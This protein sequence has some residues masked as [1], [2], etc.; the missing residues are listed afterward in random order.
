M[1]KIFIS[2]RSLLKNKTTSIIAIF[3]FSVSL[4]IALNIIA[5]VIKE[6]NVDKSYSNLDRIYR[7]V[8][9]DRKMSLR[10]DFGDYLLNTHPEIENACRYSNFASNITYENHPFSGN[11]VVTDPSF[12][13]IFSIGFLAGDESSLT[14]PD[15]VV[16]TESFARK[17]FGNSDPLGKTVIA[18][19]TY[20]LVIKGIVKDLPGNS[21]IKGDYFTSSKRKIIYESRSD[22]TGNQEYYFRLFVLTT[23]NSNPE[24]LSKKINYDLTKIKYSDPGYKIEKINLIPFRH[25]YFITSLER[26]H[27]AHAN[28]KLIKLL[29]IVSAIII[30][31]AVFNYVNLTTA[32]HTY[33]YKE[34]AI[35]KSA[36]AGRY[37]I[38][39]Q[40]MSESVIL[41]FIS[42]LLALYLSTFLEPFIENFIGTSVELGMLFKPVALLLMV[43][44]ILLLA[45]VAG[46]YPALSIS[47]LKPSVILS[48]RDALKNSSLGLRAV[49]NILQN[50]VSV[51][52][53][54]ALII[55]TRQIN[56]VRNTNFGFDAERLLR[57]DI[58]WRLAD[59]ASRIRNRLME[60]SSVKDVCFTHGSPG[61]IYSQSS[62]EVNGYGG[63]M[64]ELSTDS[65]FFNVFGIPLVKGRQPLPSDFNKVCYINETAFK[66]TG[67]DSY[68]G[69]DYHGLEVIGVVKD[70]HFENL[71]NK[72]SPL[73]IRLTSE[74]GISHMNLRI[75][76][77]NLQ[78]TIG[79]LKKTWE[80]IFPGHEL[81]YQFYDDW[82][83]SMYKSEEKLSS[84]ISFFAVFAI[85]ISCLGIMGMAEFTLRKRIKEIGIRKVNGARISEIILL[86]TSDV[87][88]Y[89][90]YGFL[91]AIIPIWFIMNSWLRTFAYHT[92]ADWWIF[93][94]AGL[95]SMIVG[96]I[97]VS[98]QSYKAATRNPL[99]SLRYE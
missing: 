16:L 50:A 40:F 20:P 85:I 41:C 11:M 63:F 22:G 65:S 42:F 71:Y 32:S 57:V 45:F 26:S 98:W 86:L 95:L 92:M 93:V 46:F 7:V 29:I 25:S 62:W 70:F 8:S 2:I 76:N 12:F 55:L 67:W 6:Y 21:S 59:K 47:R 48:K 75:S 44:G 33:R 73:A 43:A 84:A 83:D 13:Q 61:S 89:S 18:E 38:F 23:E 10:E 19:Y 77:D 17:I 9:D 72:I 14:N 68:E 54:I 15:G 78:E 5:Y 51:A 90:F 99:D 66:N 52:L 36:G 80:D 91:I 97:T 58:H 37:Q 96:L 4:S 3:G 30:L 60:Y 69:K 81:R 1:M 24:N 82:L 28:I 49:L 34:I 56:F 74:M 39:Q 35:K 79:I 53:I 87:I 88:K 94:A 31:L 27:T 64:N